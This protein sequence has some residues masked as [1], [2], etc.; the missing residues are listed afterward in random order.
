ME[1]TIADYDVVPYLRKNLTLKETGVHMMRTAA[2]GFTSSTV[3]LLYTA[4]TGFNGKAVNPQ[5][6]GLRD[7]LRIEAILQ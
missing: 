2:C 4:A 5:R 7:L 1:A 6:I 3:P